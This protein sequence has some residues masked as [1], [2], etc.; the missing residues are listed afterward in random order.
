MRLVESI[1][2]LREKAGCLLGG[3]SAH[4]SVSKHQST[5]E[6]FFLASRMP[7]PLAYV[8][9]RELLFIPF[10]GWAMACLNMIHID[11]SARGEA[12]SKVAV[13]GEQLMDR[14]KWV[15]MFPEGTRSERGASGTYKTGLPGW[16]SRRMP[17]SSPS[18]W[19]Q[20]DVA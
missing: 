1:M 12:W 15:I 14:G 16:P 3:Q 5:W 19:R 20:A 2:R 4:H 7:H 9:K 17:G 8:F 18:R 10:F 11:R 13:L 6:T